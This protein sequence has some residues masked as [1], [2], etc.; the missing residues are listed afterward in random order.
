ML[1]R[2]LGVRLIK[3]HHLQALFIPSPPTRFEKPFSGNFP[4]RFK[5]LQVRFNLYSE[6]R[7]FIRLSEGA[8]TYMV[9]ASK[10]LSDVSRPSF[11]SIVWPT[12]KHWNTGVFRSRPKGIT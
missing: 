3:T 12:S 1:T 11:K 5:L 9:I 2:S 6:N 7:H 4:V 8:E 10:H